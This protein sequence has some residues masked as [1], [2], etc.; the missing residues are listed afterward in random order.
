MLFSLIKRVPAG[1][2]I[3][4]SSLAFVFCLG[5]FCVAMMFGGP[6][7]FLVKTGDE[8]IRDTDC[9]LIESVG[10]YESARMY[11]IIGGD[12]SKGMVQLIKFYEESFPEAVKYIEE[13]YEFY[14]G[15]VGEYDSKTGLSFDSFHFSLNAASYI[16]YWARLTG[17]NPE[18][19]EIAVVSYEWPSGGISEIDVDFIDYQCGWRFV[20]PYEKGGFPALYWYCLSEN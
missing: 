16:P 13:N 11:D 14:E 19:R 12:G 8:A 17:I 18:T 5:M 7:E 1:V 3:A 6:T 15:I 4:L 2:K 10:G 9:P 20:K